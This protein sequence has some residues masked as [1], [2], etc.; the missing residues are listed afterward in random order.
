MKKEKCYLEKDEIRELFRMESLLQ[1]EV[2]KLNNLLENIKWTKRKTV[3]NAISKEVERDQ[4]DSS[5]EDES[6]GIYLTA[7]QAGKALNCS[8]NTIVKMLN[9]GSLKA[10]PRFERCRYRIPISEIERVKNSMEAD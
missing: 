3:F 9:D 8:D 6:C 2:W 5:I 7:V 1:D 4:E 10:L